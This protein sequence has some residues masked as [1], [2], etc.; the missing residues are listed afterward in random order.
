MNET[1]P[2]LEDMYEQLML[3]YHETM[4][5][6]EEY[7]NPEGYEQYLDGLSDDELTELYNDK[8]GDD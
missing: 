1:K 7:Y 3:D 4:H 6:E 2:T 8:Y 5:E